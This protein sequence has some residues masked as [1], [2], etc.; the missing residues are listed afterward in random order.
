M[1]IGNPRVGDYKI[2][3][4][5]LVKVDWQQRLTDAPSHVLQTPPVLPKPVDPKCPQWCRL[6]EGAW[7]R[8][9]SSLKGW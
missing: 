5:K 6:L 3:D 9:R 2:S 1:L 4:H 7:E 8:E